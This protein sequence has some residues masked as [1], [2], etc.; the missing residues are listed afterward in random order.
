MN[1]TGTC[2]WRV[3]P[4]ANELIKRGHNVVTLNLNQISEYQVDLITRWADVLTF[5]MVCARDLLERAKKNG[6]YTIFDT[7]DLIETVPPKHPQLKT[8]RKKR[9][10]ADFR[11][12]LSEVDMVTC[13]TDLLRERYE[14]LNPNIRKIENYIPDDVWERPP[15]KKFGD[16]IRIG[17][18]GGMSHQEDLDFIA[19]VIKNILNKN[20][21]VKFVYTGGG[22]WNT[23]NP[24]TLYRFGEDHF[25]DIPTGRRE[26]STGSKVELW[27]DRL[28]TM[29]LD[30]AL[31]PLDDNLFAR[32]KSQIKYYEYGINH[33]AGVYQKFLYQNVRHGDTGFLA[34]T[35]KEWEESI[36][37]LID[38]P[39]LRKEM[40]ERAYGDIKN[41]YTFCKHRDD[42]IGAYEQASSRSKHRDNQFFVS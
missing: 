19:P 23:G 17:W 3:Y 21:N 22:G 33:W 32:H 35:P 42:W 2:A 13:S 31:A 1:S 41:N 40:G 7:D 38:D 4:I 8:T 9:Y 28:N 36:Q 10:K 11:H 14:K 34:T 29:R 12:M 24:D 20:K 15:H 6:I 39:S 25:K 26:Y 18:A 16:T 5:Q 27:P 30:I 37:R